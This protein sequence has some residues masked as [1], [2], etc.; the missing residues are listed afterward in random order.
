ML[1]S[2]SGGLLHRKEHRP[3]PRITQITTDGL[4]V[5]HSRFHFHFT[6][7]YGWWMNL[8]ERWFS[9]LPTKKLQRS[10]HRSVQ[11]L[12]QDIRDWVETWNDNPGPSLGTRAPRRSP[13]DSPEPILKVIGALPAGT[14]ARRVH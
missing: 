7:T 1:G 6:P 9:A 13:A 4:L 11:A 5:R 10:A 3:N 12:V 2:S 8:A 14:P